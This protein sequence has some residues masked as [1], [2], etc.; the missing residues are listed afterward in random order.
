MRTLQLTC[1]IISGLLSVACE[2]K[3]D[4]YEAELDGAVLIETVS[5]AEH[6]ESRVIRHNRIAAAFGGPLIMVEQV[7]QVEDDKESQKVTAVE[8]SRLRNSPSRARR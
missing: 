3:V 1:M 8:N 6:E 4:G 5:D 7:E 2:K